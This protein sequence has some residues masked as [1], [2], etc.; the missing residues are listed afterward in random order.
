MF[1]I[2]FG[3][4]YVTFSELTNN[5]CLQFRIMLKVSPKLIL[6]VHLGL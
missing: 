6:S 2:S 1:Y 5:F 3:M 4:R